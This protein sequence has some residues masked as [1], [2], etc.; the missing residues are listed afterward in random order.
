MSTCRELMTEEVVCCEPQDTV[1]DAARLMKEH[2]VGSV[3]VCRSADSRKLLGIVT[4]R[5]L[6]LDVIALDRD[7]RGTAIADV[8]TT[9]LVT[10]LPEDNA[11]EAMEKMARYQVRRIPVVDPQGSLLGMVAQAD[12]ALGADGKKAGELVQKISRHTGADR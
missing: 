4:D 9:D 6:V 1:R 12:V 3:P 5:D 11:R 8:M 2:K 10:C 7:P